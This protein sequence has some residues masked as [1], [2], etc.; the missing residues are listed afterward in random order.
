[1]ARAGKAIGKSSGKIR[2]MVII[3]NDKRM[4]DFQTR[5]AVA[6]ESGE[7]P[8][9]IEE[10]QVRYMLNCG[11]IVAKFASSTDNNER[12]QLT[13][14]Y[15]EAIGDSIG[16][17]RVAE[18]WAEVTATAA[19]DENA[20][21]PAN[22]DKGNEDDG[23]D[24]WK[25]LFTSARSLAS[26]G[27]A[28]LDTCRQ[29]GSSEMTE[30]GSEVVCIKCGTLG[31][32]AAS[33]VASSAQNAQSN[34]GAKYS[35]NRTSHYRDRILQWMGC[36]FQGNLS[37]QVIDKLLLQLRKERV[38][39]VENWSK[40]RMV[41]LLKRAG[42]NEYYEHSNYFISQLSGKP[43]P[44]TLDRETIEVLMEMFRKFEV[45]YERHKHLLCD[46][47]HS[48][49]KNI[50]TISYVLRKFLGILGLHEYAESF[51]LLK[52]MDKI[53]AY[54]A[55]FAQCCKDLGWKFIPSL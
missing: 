13:I 17:A 45:A 3:L 35:Y 28:G 26:K 18:Q 25:R 49:R 39:S 1:M 47:R 29:C 7:D 55:V 37:S 43:V 11:G 5:A 33:I 8:T 20:P 22:S 10:E 36:E 6:A 30:D 16:A 44:F 19:V 52:N 23:L 48:K 31:T 4:Q 14:Q 54:E 38:T 15:L 2:D 24:D 27:V 53:R 9:A 51:S 42:L 32:Q 21:T 40:R 50:I 34:G 12:R 41:S 46:S